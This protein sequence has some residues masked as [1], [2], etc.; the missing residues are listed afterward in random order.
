MRVPKSSFALRVELFHAERTSTIQ[1][2]WTSFANSPASDAY[3]VNNK[4]RCGRLLVLF[5][6]IIFRLHPFFILLFFLFPSFFL[7][8]SSTHLTLK[9]LTNV[10]AF[11]FHHSLF[12]STLFLLPYFLPFPLA[13]LVSSLNFSH[14]IIRFYFYFPAC[15]QFPPSTSY[16]SSSSSL[17]TIPLPP[18][19]PTRLLF[20]G[21]NLVR[22]SYN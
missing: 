19:P 12:F 16:P 3:S 18:A 14:I 9:I 17:Q 22:T 15:H 11:L 8:S 4:T 1:L 13:L 7:S 21:Y 20:Q 6:L 2:L 10:F 5:L